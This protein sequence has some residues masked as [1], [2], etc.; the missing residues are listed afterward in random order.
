[1]ASLSDI[2]AVSL[3]CWGPHFSG[4]RGGVQLAFHPRKPG[5]ALLQP[6]CASRGQ[7]RRNEDSPTV[8]WRFTT[9]DARIKLMRLY[10]SLE[11]RKR[12][13]QKNDVAKKD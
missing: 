12:P 9:A 1:M 5:Q 13:S 3:C 8:N 6:R 7:D 2:G 11:P 4:M 10:P